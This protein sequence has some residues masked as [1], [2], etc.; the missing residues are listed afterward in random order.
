MHID[1]VYGQLL[2][3]P[4][5]VW[6]FFY[7]MLTCRLAYT[8][9]YI[10]IDVCDNCDSYSAV[11]SFRKVTFVLHLCEFPVYCSSTLS[12]SLS[13]AINIVFC[14]G[15]RHRSLLFPTGIL[16]GSTQ[17]SGQAGSTDKKTMA[18]NKG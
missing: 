13:Y 7:F 14:R 2:V 3:V 4:F 16:R 17:N 1:S 15:D 11:L 12:H 9:Q 18:N 10:C 8:P 5:L 6:N